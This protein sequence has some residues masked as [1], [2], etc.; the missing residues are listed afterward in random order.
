MGFFVQSGS[1]ARNMLFI[2]V[3][4]IFSFVYVCGSECGFVHLSASA[5]GSQRHQLPLELEL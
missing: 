3:C 5:L 1:E 2:G 4:I